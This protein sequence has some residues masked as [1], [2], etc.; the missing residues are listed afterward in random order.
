MQTLR[1][2]STD[3]LIVKVFSAS[4]AVVYIITA[5]QYSTQKA[6]I[7]QYNTAT[8]S[9]F[10]VDRSINRQEG[11]TCHEQQTHSCSPQEFY[12]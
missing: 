11:H 10:T 3:R 7:K 5:V 12:Q 2:T 9:I 8:N 1:S 6:A 4:V